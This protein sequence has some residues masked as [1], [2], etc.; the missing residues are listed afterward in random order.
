M[1]FIVKTHFQLKQNAAK[2]AEEF[3]LNNDPP[4][5]WWLTLRKILGGWDP[6]ELKEEKIQIEALWRC[7]VAR[8]RFWLRLVRAVPMSVLYMCMLYVLLPLIGHFPQPPIRGNLDFGRLIVPAVFLLILLTF[9]VIDAVLLHEGLLKQ[10]AWWKTYWPNKTF[11]IYN[12]MVE[13]RRPK[14]ES[15]L[16]DYWDILLIAKRTEA[17]GNLSYYPFFILSL[18]IVARLPYFGNWTWPPVLLV[19]LFLHFCLA[20]YAAWRLP[21]AAR[22]YRDE[23]L[24]RLKR[25]RRQG[26]IDEQ[27][28]PEATDRMIEEVQSNHQGAFSYLWEQPAVRAL[29]LPSGSFGIATLLQYLPH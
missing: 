4:E 3:G 1:Y 7:Y 26:L 13:S 11:Q 21:S 25:R 14:H 5:K 9:V 17:V 6:P 28:L 8:G 20:L 2:L 23:V 24:A 12:Y 18:L 19:A 22:K 29:L 16:A 27:R 15:N 10:L